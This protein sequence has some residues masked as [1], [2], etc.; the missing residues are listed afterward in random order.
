MYIPTTHVVSLHFKCLGFTYPVSSYWALSENGWLKV[1][2]F[3]DFAGSGSIHAYAGAASLAAAYMTGP[4][5]DRFE[6]D[7][8][9]FR[10]ADRFHLDSLLPLSFHSIQTHFVI[11][12]SFSLYFFRWLFFTC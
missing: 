11:L 6:K 4:R 5:H 7:G 9:F 12:F 3:E 1:L 10:C 8:D 2:G